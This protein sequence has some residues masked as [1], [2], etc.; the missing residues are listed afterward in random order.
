MTN[1]G[2]GRGIPF[3]KKKNSKPNENLL[4]DENS[5]VVGG[6]STVT[7]TETQTQKHNTETA[8]VVYSSYAHALEKWLRLSRLIPTYIQ[9][10]LVLYCLPHK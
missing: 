6:L 4:A 2:V 3:S 5:G 7:E 9:R 1:R 8:C 10:V